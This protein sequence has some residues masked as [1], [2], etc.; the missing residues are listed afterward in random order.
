M[1][2]A[3]QLNKELTKA[4]AP[5]E[6]SSFGTVLTQLETLVNRP[7]SAQP[8][9]DILLTYLPNADNRTKE[10]IAIALTEKGLSPASKALLEMFKHDPTLEEPQRWVVGKALY[11]IDDPELYPE[12]LAICKERKYQSSRGMLIHMLAKIKTEEA[13]N[14][15]IVSLDDPTVL[16]DLY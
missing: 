14:I 13:F 12:I 4:G 8:Y 9:I 16:L 7:V 11:T 2:L 1:D 15:L 6:P 5:T 10:F 3:N